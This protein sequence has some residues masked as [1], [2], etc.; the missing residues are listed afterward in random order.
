MLVLTGSELLVKRVLVNVLLVVVGCVAV[1]MF[2]V[3]VKEFWDVC[4]GYDGMIGEDEGIGLW[5]PARE[6][7]VNLFRLV[8]VLFLML[9]PSDSKDLLRYTYNKYK[10]K[11]EES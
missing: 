2:E 8:A 1:W 7:S 9:L 10:R 4:D 5:E 6:E 11:I 3:M